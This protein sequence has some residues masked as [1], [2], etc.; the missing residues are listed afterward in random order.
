MQTS[1]LNQRR[2]QKK[3]L[4]IVSIFHRFLGEKMVQTSS[5]LAFT[6][7]LAVVPLVTVV[8]SVAH[9]VPY[10]DQLMA[11]LDMLVKDGLLPSGVAGSVV[12]SVGRFSHK[13]Q[14]LTVAGLA[15]L[16]LTAVL[17]MN[18]VEHAFNNLWGAKPRRWLARLVLYIFAMAVWPFILGALAA[19][20][21]FAVSASLG[22]FDQPPWFRRG[23]LKAASMVLL[24]LFF[25]FLYYVV[26]NARVSRRA[27]FVGAVFST[28]AF[29]AMQK[30]FE[31]Y[32][33]SSAMLKSIYGAF[34]VF[35]AFLVWLQISWAVV[36]FGGLIVATLDRPAR[37]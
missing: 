26:P 19:A 4:G 23:L 14:Q 25:W 21:S 15:F 36:L 35:P 16:G 37:H 11:R 10:F 13:A 30:V 5:A 6:T 24:V 22:F 29:S 32:L 12:G 33:A 17:L 28:L 31:L 1:S 18:T 8:L 27:A 7:L 3:R 20:M 9:V 34:A 2:H